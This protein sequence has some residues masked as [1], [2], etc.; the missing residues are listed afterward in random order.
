M[1]R[2]PIG[3]SSAKLQDL[4]VEDYERSDLHKMIP[5]TGLNVFG[6]YTA[7]DFG[8]VFIGLGT[9]RATQKFRDMLQEAISQT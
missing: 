9:E 1:I 6:F 3:N 8:S 7:N 2:G 5:D 4:Q